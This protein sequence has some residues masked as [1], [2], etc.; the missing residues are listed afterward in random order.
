[1]KVLASC[2]CKS[3]AAVSA[4]FGGVSL[5]EMNASD[6]QPE[7]P[8]SPTADSITT[9]G[10]LSSKLS[11]K[12]PANESTTRKTHA[13][14][15]TGTAGVAAGFPLVDQTCIALDHSRYCLTAEQMRNPWT[16]HFDDS[17]ILGNKTQP[18]YEE[19]TRNVSAAQKD[20]LKQYEGLLGKG[21]DSTKELAVVQC[22]DPGT[23]ERLKNGLSDC[24]KQ[25]ET[26]LK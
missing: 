5:I 21:N 16:R 8:R 2:Q 3:R 26:R 14:F 1:M 23:A 9:C 7:E 20:L 25:G 15:S 12:Q 10:T 18:S 13:A 24:H 6:P 19:T 17:D 4:S 22:K 11:D